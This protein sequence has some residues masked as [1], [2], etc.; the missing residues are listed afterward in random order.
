MTPSSTPSGAP[1]GV[2][3][4][5][6]SVVPSTTPS[7]NTPSTTPSVNPSVVPGHPTKEPSASLAPSYSPST[8][9]SGRTNIIQSAPP[10]SSLVGLSNALQLSQQNGVTFSSS[11][12]PSQSPSVT[13][14]RIVGST[15]LPSTQFCEP[16]SAN[17][18]TCS[19]SDSEPFC[20][21]YRQTDHCAFQDSF[22]S[23]IRNRKDTYT[24]D[25]LSLR[26][27]GYW[28]DLIDDKLGGKL[29]AEEENIASPAL[30][31]C[32]ANIF[33][34]LD[35]FVPP[36]S[37]GF[38]VKAVGFHSN[39]GIFVLP[40][41][42]DSIELL[43]GKVM[44]KAD[45][46]DALVASRAARVIIEDY[47]SGESPNTLPNEYKF[48][49]FNGT[50]GSIVYVSNPGTPC[51]CFA[52]L[53]PSWNRIDNEGCFSP[54]NGPV[55]N[56]QCI[57][58]DRTKKQPKQMKGMDLCSSVPPLD[59]SLLVKLTTTAQ[60]VSQRVG[61]YMRVDMFVSNGSPI[62]GEFTAGHTGGKVHCSA[63]IDKTTGCADSC[64]LGKLWSGNGGTLSHGGPST[65]LPTSLVGFSDAT[66]EQKCATKMA[67]IKS[68]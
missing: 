51:A 34:G 67:S 8:L 63:P 60:T 18:N 40:Q 32:S 2:P 5:T 56:G 49:M 31:Y 55:T 47:V 39:K 17:T 22:L 12:I 48:H 52:E 28:Y 57:H 46:Q 38:V 35:S 66:W 58:I 11:A 4:T 16:L 30:K 33:N 44:S 62:I 45:V 1:V 29:F 24:S 36:A 68:P 20:R 65:A 13:P 9:P 14:K 23:L 3:S 6:P 26:S 15:V 7:S 37:G 50:V 64:H 61:V 59:P 10:S 25:P 21:P 19:A 53:D 42:F 41:G 43:S 54:G 27:G